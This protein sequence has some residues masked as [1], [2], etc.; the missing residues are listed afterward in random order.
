MVLCH[1]EYWHR[2]KRCAILGTDVAYGAVQLARLLFAHQVPID[3]ALRTCYAKSGTY[4]AYRTTSKACE[5]LRLHP[6]ARTELQVSQL[7]T[8]EWRHTLRVL[9]V[10]YQERFTHLLVDEFQV[11]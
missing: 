6:S 8:D 9:K 10:G 11:C 5:I 3:I 7:Y 1:A 4:I 2:V